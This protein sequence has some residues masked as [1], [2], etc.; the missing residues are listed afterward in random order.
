F[1]GLACGFHASLGGAAAGRAGTPLAVDHGGPPA[2]H[3]AERDQQRLDI[4][5]GH[6]DEIQPDQPAN[7]AE[8]GDH[9][10]RVAEGLALGGHATIPGRYT[11]LPPRFTALSTCLR[12]CWTE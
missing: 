5:G 12:V 2:Q 8:H 9:A 11:V 3:N 7:A 6:L 1:H 10:D 4:A